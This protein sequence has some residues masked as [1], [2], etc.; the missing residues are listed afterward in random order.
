MDGTWMD[1]M[2]FRKRRIRGA[3]KLVRKCQIAVARHELGAYGPMSRFPCYILVTA[4]M[5]I[6]AGNVI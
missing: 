2:S 5:G 1:E 4:G 6:R 3:C